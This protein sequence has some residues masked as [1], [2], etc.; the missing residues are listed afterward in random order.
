MLSNYQFQPGNKLKNMLQLWNLLYIIGMITGS[1]N[2]K[3]FQ[4]KPQT[5]PES[6]I[7]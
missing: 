7:R 2:I 3:I 1:K 5:K 6:G 4:K